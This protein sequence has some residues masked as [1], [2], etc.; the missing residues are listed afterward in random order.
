M[1]T[2]IKHTLRRMRGQMIGW[3]IGLGIYVLLMVSIYADIQ[4]IDFE[5]IWQSYPQDMMAFF[6]DALW[7]FN[8]PAGYLEVYFFNYMPVIIGIFAVGACA[9]LI[10]GEEESGTLDLVQAHPVSRTALFWGR[11]IAFAAALAVILLVTWLTWLLPVGGSSLDLTVI[12]FLRPYLPLFAE[13]LLFGFLALLLSM[14]LPSARLAGMITG[15]LLIA[16]YLMVGLANINEDLQPIVDYTPLHFYQGGDAVHGLDWSWLAGLL[17]V[18]AVFTL[19]AW[20]RFMQRDIRVGGE[21]SWRVPLLKG[22]KQ[23]AS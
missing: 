15:G 4:Q 10:V 19:L 13:L 9:S 18:A 1:W 20:W 17:A 2:I 3:G 5:T 14:L 12:E 16:N 22:R 6:G 11:V 23:A 21:G 8:T 7:Q